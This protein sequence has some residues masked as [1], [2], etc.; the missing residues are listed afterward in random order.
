MLRWVRDAYAPDVESNC[1]ATSDSWSFEKMTVSRSSY[2]IPFMVNRQHFRR[3]SE[4]SAIED[5]SIAICRMIDKDGVRI[6]FDLK[7][8][9]CKCAQYL[10]KHSQM[11]TTFAHHA[12]L[13]WR[14]ED[15]PASPILSNINRCIMN[16]IRRRTQFDLLLPKNARIFRRLSS[17]S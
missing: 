10:Y 9:H 13:E 2:E 16:I 12:C 15:S 1:Q 8:D 4:W 17:R 6:V 14:S 11:Q 5:R 7:R 3:R